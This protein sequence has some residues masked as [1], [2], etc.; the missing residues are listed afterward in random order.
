MRAAIYA[1]VITAKNGQDPYVQNATDLVGPLRPRL[2]K[3]TDTSMN[4]APDGLDLIV[5][6]SRYFIR[7]TGN[8]KSFGRSAFDVVSYFRRETDGNC[9]SDESSNAK[10]S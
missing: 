6:M 2:F 9:C 7:L 3:G 8:L 5:Q 1:R 4:G 10:C